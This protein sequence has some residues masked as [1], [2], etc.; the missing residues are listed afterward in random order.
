MRKTWSPPLPL[1]PMCS[2]SWKVGKSRTRWQR[3]RLRIRSVFPTNVQLCKEFDLQRTILFDL[4][5]FP[6]GF[7]VRHV[8]HNPVHTHPQKRL[9]KRLMGQ[10]IIGLIKSGNLYVLHGRCPFRNLCHLAPSLVPFGNCHLSLRE[11]S[12]PGEVTF[13]TVFTVRNVAFE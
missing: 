10:V 6:I 3:L 11:A 8:H 13:R 4:E 2:V 12:N 5:R 7:L 9:N 1:P